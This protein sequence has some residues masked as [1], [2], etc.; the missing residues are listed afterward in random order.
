M[1]GLDDGFFQR[2]WRRTLLALA[3]HCRREGSLCPCRVLLDT[4]EVDGLD[5]TWKA[6][7]LVRRALGEG[8]RLEAVLTDT[9]VFAGFN[10]L[11]PE[12]LYRETGVPAVAV[13]MYPP[14]REAV[15]RALRLHFPDWRERLAVLEEA[16]SRLRSAECRRG[17]LLLAA[18]GMEPRD[19]WRLACSLQ[20]YT[21]HPEPLFTAHQAASMLSRTL[22]PL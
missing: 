16:W 9:V 11:D 6:A 7:R 15:E 2:G 19:A 18:Y 20:L 12:R 14:R 10:I 22:G 5:A 4:V 1:A 8:F 21:R 3:V 17:R 13:Y